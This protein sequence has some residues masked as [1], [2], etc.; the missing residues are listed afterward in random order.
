MPQPDHSD[1]PSMEEILASI[2]R[3][4]AED[5]ETPPPAASAPADAAPGDDILELT[6]KVEDDGT[7]V[8]LAAAGARRTLAD[9]PAE[10]SLRSESLFEKKPSSVV[11]N[12]PKL[13]PPPVTAEPPPAPP[14]PK[15]EPR[16]AAAAPVPPPAAESAA[17]VERPV[18]SEHTPPPAAPI[19]ERLVS[20]ATAAASVAALAQLADLGQHGQVSNQPLGDSGRTLE[21]LVR[22][23]LRPILKTWCDSNLAPLVERLVREEIQRMARDAQGR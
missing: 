10:P 6:E 21:S 17:A 12:E 20:S 18:A 23:L 7:V 2:R 13:D 8:S 3:I 4:I 5:A 11:D 19:E 1:Q 22:E 16:P 9:T 15:V 14:P